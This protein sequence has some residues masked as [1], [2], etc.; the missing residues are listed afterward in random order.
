MALKVADTYEEALRLCELFEVEPEEELL[1]LT[2]EQNRLVA[3]IQAIM[4]KP[5]LLL[6]DHPYDMIGTKRYGLLLEELKKL[7]A[8]G[9]TILIAADAYDKVVIPCSRYIF[10]KDGT[11]HAQYNSAELPKR[12]KVIMIE[13]G[14][15]E[16]MRTDRMRILYR[17]ETHWCF[18]YREDTAAELALQIHQTGC[19]NFMV[20]ELSMEEEVYGDYER[21]KL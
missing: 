8:N 2:F 14:N 13:D 16:I 15:P 20:N 5:A 1:N 11:I 10:L 12:S 4:A 7:K 21:W 6:L 3:M 9:T 18:L 19:S 17:T